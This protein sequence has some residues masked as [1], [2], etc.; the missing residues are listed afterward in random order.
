MPRYSL[1][2]CGP[3]DPYAAK[4]PKEEIMQKISAPAARLTL[5]AVA[6]LALAPPDRAP[7]Q[8][9]APNLSGTYRCQP[10]PS[11]CQWSGQ[12]FT[13]AQSG[14]RLD[15]KSD[16]GDVGQGLLSSNV[17]LSVGAPWNMLGVVLPD[18]RI[19]WSNGTLWLKQ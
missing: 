7:A 6:F 1:G 15:M 18:N 17:T 9:A 11:S 16:K 10:E 19:Q 14:T 3:A 2:L 13:V 12:S 8:P 5:A 4:Y